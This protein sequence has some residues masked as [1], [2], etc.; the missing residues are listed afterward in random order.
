VIDARPNIEYPEYVFRLVGRPE[1]RRSEKF[2]ERR[3]ERVLTEHYRT[4]PDSVLSTRVL[5]WYPSCRMPVAPSGAD[6]HLEDVN[7]NAELSLLFS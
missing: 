2:C 7:S 3:T 5:T 4:H 6:L 1:I